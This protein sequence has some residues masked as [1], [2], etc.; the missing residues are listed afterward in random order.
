MTEKE[1]KAIYNSREWKEKRIEILTRDCW[2]CQDC[3]KRLKDAVDSGNRL[4]GKDAKIR[5]ADEVH[6]IRELREYPELAFVNNNLI[7]LCS[8]CHNI[9]HG[10]YPHKFKRKKP[11]VSEEKW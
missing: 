10:R 7:S 8:E 4:N 1:I 9:R 3:R 11:I 6:H 2:E 5:R